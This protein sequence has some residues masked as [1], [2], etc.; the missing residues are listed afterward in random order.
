MS[1]KWRVVL[2]LALAEFLAM[3]LW[4]SA[5]AVTPALTTAWGLTSGDAAWLTMAVQFGFVLGAFLSALFNVADV[6]SPRLVFAIGATVGAVANG[7]IAALANG[8]ALALLLRFISMAAVYPVGMK[9]MPPLASCPCQSI[10][11]R[12]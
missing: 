6:W 9:I 2:L 10:W 3:G 8:I 5:S 11:T 12:P 7:L 1:E 4:F